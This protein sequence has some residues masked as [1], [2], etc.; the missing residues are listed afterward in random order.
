MRTDFLEKSKYD[1][2]YLYMTYDNA[3]ALQVSLVTGMRIDDV[4]K[5]KPTDI[6]GCRLSYVAQKT[7]KLGEVVLPRSLADRLKKNG[8]DRWCFPH[9]D[10]RRRHRTRQ[11][12]WKDVK[13]ACETLRQIE[14]LDD[15]NIAPHSAR[16]TFAVEDKALHGMAHTQAALQ[17]E[18]RYT[19]EIYADSDH[20]VGAPVPYR[21]LGPLI[22][23]INTLEKRI[24]SLLSL[25]NDIHQIVT[26][27][28]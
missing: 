19:T 12:V 20:L 18:S 17:H 7:G 27:S 23:R 5:I 13:K 8:S 3:L 1:K 28:V 25:V 16:K 9:R 24:T 10:D 4:L 14:Y 22:S 15:R 6:E 26:K 2:L 21:D 11:A